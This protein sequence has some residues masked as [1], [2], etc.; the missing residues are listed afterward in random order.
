MKKLLAATILAIA[1]GLTI[2]I[3][4]TVLYLIFYVIVNIGW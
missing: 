3:P 4:A 2:G 1:V